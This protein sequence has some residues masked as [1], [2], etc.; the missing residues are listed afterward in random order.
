MC[1]L[2]GLC[3]VGA[4]GSEVL[5]HPKLQSEFKL[6]LCYVRPH[7]GY[8]SVA[9]INYHDQRNLWREEFICAQD[10]RER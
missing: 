10:S 4:H 5:G 6:D 9:L 1:H 7:I 2:P 3:S 8:F